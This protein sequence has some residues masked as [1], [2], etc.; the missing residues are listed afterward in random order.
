MTLSGS[1]KEKV[2][3][4]I[5]N[6]TSVII[7]TVDEN[8]YPHTRVMLVPRKI[9]GLKHFYF[10]TN[11]SSQK[12]KQLRN[13]AKSCIYFYDSAR[14]VGVT[15]IGT[16]EVLEDEVSKKMIWRTGDEIYYSKGVC[17][18][19]YCVLKFTAKTLRYYS[20]FNPRDFEINE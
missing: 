8:G 1:L 5:N 13:N 17:D 3:K 2:E 15:L 12:V 9:N 14:Y 20:D 10:T 6:A 19:D 18:P 7:S 4:L 16:T 11:T